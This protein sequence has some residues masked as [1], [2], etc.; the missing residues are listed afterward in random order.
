MPTD[1]RNVRFVRSASEK[2]AFLTDHP[3]ITFLGR[4][5]VGKSTLVNLLVCQKNFMKAS[6][7]PGRTQ[8]I[9]YALVDQKFYLADVP[10]YGFASFQ[11]DSFAGLMKDFLE[12][13]PSLKMIYLLID[14]RRLLTEEDLSFVDYL[15]SLS[16]PF[17][18]IFTKTDKLSASDRHYLTVQEQ[19]LG[20]IPFLESGIDDNKSIDRIRHSINEVISRH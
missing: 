15:S 16:A 14:S 9:N 4:S 11:R 17:C 20:A 12:D 13:N 8:L 1:F 5:N 3:V 2:K 19:K 18:Y 10:G 7:T 6:K